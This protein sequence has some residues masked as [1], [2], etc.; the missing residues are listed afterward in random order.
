MTSRPL[1]FFLGKAGFLMLLY[2][3]FAGAQQVYGATRALLET[4]TRFKFM[5]QNH[6][7]VVLRSHSVVTGF[8]FNH[9]KSAVTGNPMYGANDCVIWLRNLWPDKES[10]T[11]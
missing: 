7:N 1:S 2:T 8:T 10:N 9:D 6:G 11:T 3:V 5:E 4:L